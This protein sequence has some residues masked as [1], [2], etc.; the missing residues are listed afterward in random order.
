MLVQMSKLALI[1]FDSAILI[2][3]ISVSGVLMTM[4]RMLVSLICLICRSILVSA[5]SWLHDGSDLT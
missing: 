4:F 3:N 2:R 1:W 5:S